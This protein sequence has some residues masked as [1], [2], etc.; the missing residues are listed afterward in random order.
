M[1]FLVLV[2]LIPILAVAAYSYYVRFGERRSQELQ[3]NLEVASAVATSFGDYVRD[4]Q[5]VETAIGVV[6]TSPTPPSREEVNRLFVQSAK[7]YPSIRFYSWVN[8][9]GQTVTSSEPKAVGLEV[10]D[11]PY[12]QQIVQ[13]KDSAVSD[14]LIGRVTGQP[15]VIIARAV[16]DAQ[17]NLLGAMLASVD[18]QQLG[19][20]LRVRLAEQGSIDIIDATGRLV[21]HFPEVSLSFDQRNLSAIEP[22]FSPALRGQDVTATFVSPIDGQTQLGAFAP[23]QGL[24][25]VAGA[26]RPESVAIAPI[27]RPLLTDVGLVLIVGLISLLVALAI[28]RSIAD[29][30]GSLEEHAV[31]VGRGELERRVHLAG[32]VELE[33]LAAAFNRSAGEIQLRES[34]REDDVHMISHDLRVPLT[35]IQGQAQ[36]LQ[37]MLEQAGAGTRPRRSISAILTGAKRMNAMIEDLVDTARLESGQLRLS[38]VPIDLRS[39]LSELTERLSGVIE[40]ERIRAEL[41]AD[42]PQ[43]LADPDRL[44]RILTNLLTNA[45]KYSEPGTPVTVAM[46]ARDGQ[47]IITVADRGPGIPPDELPHLFQR[48]ARTREARERREGLGLGLYISRM[49][50][51]AHG[52]RIWAKSEPGKGS[53]FAFTLPVAEGADEH[54]DEVA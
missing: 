52:G 17:G 43:V 12:F 11:R 10:G 15:T 8:P 40:S 33:D 22:I 13:G 44:E 39:F 23:I 45:L 28:G 20:E 29:P 2:V 47:V 16:R 51:E 3:S 49:L 9:Q 1:L 25:W 32:P 37:R 41:P 42:L 54:Q 6:M 30:I 18:P 48:F 26:S 27:I 21:Y 50:V 19:G 34:Q 36:L 53:S 14:L 31:A 35:V 46:A 24:G 7:G 38:L 4:I 5:H